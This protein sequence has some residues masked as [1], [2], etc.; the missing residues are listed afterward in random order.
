M[1]LISKIFRIRQPSSKSIKQNNIF[2]FKSHKL[3]VTKIRSQPQY[4]VTNSI[5]QSIRQNTLL[6]FDHFVWSNM[7]I[8]HIR[9]H[10]IYHT[11]SQDTNHSKYHS[12]GSHKLV[13]FYPHILCHTHPITQ[14][15]SHTLKH[16]K[17]IEA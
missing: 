7:L 4:S 16:P 12:S 9:S 3:K 8:T 2:Y 10:Q 6:L 5:K 11:N 14:T 17:L 1:K 13:K 15:Q